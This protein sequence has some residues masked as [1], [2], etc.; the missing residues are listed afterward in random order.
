MPDGR[1]I[2]LQIPGAWVW[3]EYSDDRAPMNNMRLPGP[4][5]VRLEARSG[6]SS[7][8]IC[9]PIFFNADPG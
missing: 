3:M 4:P 5:N 7:V 2:R 6:V 1:A 9:L 8:P